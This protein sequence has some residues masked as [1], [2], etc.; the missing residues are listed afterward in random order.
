MH[1]LPDTYYP[2]KIKIDNYWLRSLRGRGYKD[3]KIFCITSDDPNQSA[4]VIQGVLTS[5]HIFR[6]SSGHNW[7][8][9]PSYNGVHS[10]VIKPLLDVI[11]RDKQHERYFISR[12]SLSGEGIDSLY[13]K[14]PIIELTEKKPISK[15]GDR[16]NLSIVVTYTPT[17][18]GE[19]YEV[20]AYTRP[21][22]YDKKNVEK[23]TWLWQNKIILSRGLGPS[24]ALIMDL[25][26]S[27][28]V[29]DD[30]RLAW[31]VS[32]SGSLLKSSFMG[33]QGNRTMGLWVTLFKEGK[34]NTGTQKSS[35]TT[36]VVISSDTCPLREG[37]LCY[38][39]MP[40][41]EFSPRDSAFRR[42]LSV[43]NMR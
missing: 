35:R 3:K 43:K 18:A 34:N 41:R 9:C 21:S 33:I 5:G 39:L 19:E 27:G 7:Q 25:L 32:V 8:G 4:T 31:S 12:P 15:W 29:L 10:S 11:T 1:P 42:L 30:G 28:F 17:D 36:P 16:I 37:G 22:E 2:R 20:R 6:V 13:V 40:L 38:F 24:D 23:E 14:I 26:E